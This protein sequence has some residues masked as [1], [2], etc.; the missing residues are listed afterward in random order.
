MSKYDIIVIGG[1]IL[2]IS[3]AYH[4]LKAGL[5]VALIERNKFPQDASVRNFGQIV[6]SGMDEKWQLLGRESL[7]IYKEIQVETDISVQQEGSIYIASNEEEMTLIEELATLNVQ[8]GY[9]S[10]IWT[11]KQCLDH[12]P[13][14]KKGYVKGGLFFPEE[15]KLD[16]RVAAQRI[17]QYCIE[18]WKLTYIPQTAIKE[19]KRLKGEVQLTSTCQKSFRAE[20]VFLC[21]GN[22]FQLLYPDIFR[23]SDIVAVKLQML[24]TVPQKRQ[25]IPGSV[26]T[27]WTIRRY[28][29]F[30]AC[31][32]Y[33]GITA[34][35]DQEAFRH[36]WGV[37]ILFKQA[38]DGA[39]IVGDSHEYAPAADSGVLGFDA[40][41]EVNCFMLNQAQRI[42]DLEDWQI[43]K[44][45]LGYYCQCKTQD[46]FNHTIDDDI[47][48]ITGIGGKGMTASLGYARA[49]VN[50]LLSLNPEII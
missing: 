7:S 25:R 13:G 30:R 16:P 17:I 29:S 9:S 1:G 18:K 49:N 2:G 46:I 12:Y 19:I 5:K 37:H 41:N 35:E 24:E 45:W 27:G 23:A 8:H 44:T 34:K 28:E 6:P 4:C 22:E 38:P 48:I 26:L 11:K 39:L 21:S 32:S 31:P 50:K 33:A 15:I 47:H 36:Q 43:R 3:H 40:S 14:L 42:F 20:K 10:S